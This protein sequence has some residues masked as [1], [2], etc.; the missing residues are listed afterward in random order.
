M[1][2]HVARDRLWF[3]PIEP[4]TRLKP[5]RYGILEPVTFAR[6]LVRAQKLDLIL[7][8]LVGFDIRRPA[9]GDGQGLLR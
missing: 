3:A 4:G 2:S 6:R 7:L 1:L 9:P 5:N 8:P